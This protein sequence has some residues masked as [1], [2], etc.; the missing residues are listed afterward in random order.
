MRQA[1]SFLKSEAARLNEPARFQLTS[2]NREAIS[3]ELTTDCRVGFKMMQN[4]VP[5]YKRTSSS[6]VITRLEMVQANCMSKTKK[7]MV[8]FNSKNTRAVNKMY[9]NYISH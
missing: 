4:S 5:T 2:C 3:T 1:D 8:N 7:Y 6:H 9:V